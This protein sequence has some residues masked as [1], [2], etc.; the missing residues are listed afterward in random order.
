MNLQ[1][2]SAIVGNNMPPLDPQQE[3]REEIDTLSFLK[4][5]LER[6]DQLFNKQNQDHKETLQLADQLRDRLLRTDGARQNI[7]TLLNKVRGT[8]Q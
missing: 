6:L 8:T 3:T 4:V 7:S 1:H 5:E 2:K